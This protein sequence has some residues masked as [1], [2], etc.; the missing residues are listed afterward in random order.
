[1]VRQPSALAT[2]LP[3]PGLL[4][5]LHLHLPRLLL[6]M[7]NREVPSATVEVEMLQENPL[8]PAM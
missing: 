1:M 8:A 4:M 5:R 7:A 6:E 3:L 2:A